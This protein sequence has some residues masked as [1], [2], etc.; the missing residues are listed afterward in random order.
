MILQPNSLC[1]LRCG[2]WRLIHTRCWDPV[3]RHFASGSVSCDRAS[4]SNPCLTHPTINSAVAP[5]AQRMPVH[6]MLLRA[7]LALPSFRYSWLECR[8]HITVRRT[9]SCCNS[10]SLAGG[11]AATDSMTV[12]CAEAAGTPVKLVIVDLDGTILDTE[13]LCLE[14]RALAGDGILIH[15]CLKHV[16]QPAVVN[17]LLVLSPSPADGVSA[18][19]QGRKPGQFDIKGPVCRWP[20]TLWPATGST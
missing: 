15:T 4:T 5:L 2:G 16:P 18:Q 10:G 3:M 14:V 17:P 1:W 8:A 19:G 6:R 13:S 9:P 7:T 12:D 20:R 11:T